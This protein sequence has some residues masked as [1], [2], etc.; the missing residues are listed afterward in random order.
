MTPA[1][2]LLAS[3]SHTTTGTA[4]TPSPTHAETR[5]QQVAVQVAP[6]GS[7]SRGR[8]RGGQVFVY[9]IRRLPQREWLPTRLESLE[10]HT[11]GSRTTVAGGM[12]ERGS[13]VAGVRGCTVHMHA[14]ARQ[15]VLLATVAAPGGK[16]A[17]AAHTGSVKT[18][19]AMHA[20]GDASGCGGHVRTPPRPAASLS[21]REGARVANRARERE[22]ALLSRGRAGCEKAAAATGPHTDALI[23]LVAKGT[24]PE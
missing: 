22:G 5:P 20:A 8:Q 3:P 7:S 11:R 16:T 13:C 14:R 2:V 19:P 12:R 1:A 10:A 15:V 9:T 24:E 21:S 23:P 17:Q 18:S 6:R 4:R